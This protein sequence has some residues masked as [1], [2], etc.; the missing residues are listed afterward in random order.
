M[1]CLRML[2]FS[3]F[4]ASISFFFT[5][6]DGDPLKKPLSFQPF[7]VKEGLSSD[8]VN[9]VAIQGDQVWFGTEGGGAALFDRVKK[10]WKTYT[11]KGD[12]TDKFDRGK[13]IEG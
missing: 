6:A 11:T 3:I 7:T 2:S 9:A 1:Q 12:P 4:I 10:T 8:M 13:R 5:H